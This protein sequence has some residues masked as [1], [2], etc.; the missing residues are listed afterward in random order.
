MLFVRTDIA[1]ETSAGAAAAAT[2]ERFGPVDVLINNA[3]IYGDYEPRNHSLEYLK[4][5]FD[6]N[7]RGQ[8]I[9]AAAVA[10]H[11]A[12]QRWGRIINV[13]SIAAYLHQLSA[14]SDPETS[15][16]ATTPT[17]CRSGACS[18]SPGTWPD[19]SASTT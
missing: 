6:V 2:I 9:M 15:S 18:A 19:S 3:A 5:V 8:W 14:L 4:R 17:P 10:P 13:G 1:D 7:V 11:L 16:S 12:R